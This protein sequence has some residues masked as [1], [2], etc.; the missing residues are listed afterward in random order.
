ML[1]FIPLP[2]SINPEIRR[3][4]AVLRCI[5]AAL[6]LHPS[7]SFLIRICLVDVRGRLAIVVRQTGTEAAA[8]ASK[9]TLNGGEAGCRIE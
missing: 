4:I 2:T 6:P 9:P 3:R 1:Q 7:V 8:E 5:A